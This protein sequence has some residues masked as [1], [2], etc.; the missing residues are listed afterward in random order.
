MRTSASRSSSS[1]NVMVEREVK[2]REKDA[3]EREERGG[4]A[5]SSFPARREGA[6]RQSALL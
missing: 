2:R 4:T 6:L 5:A 1:V 3:E